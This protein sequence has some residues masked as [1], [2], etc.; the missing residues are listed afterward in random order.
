[1][2]LKTRTRPERSRFSTPST[3]PR[4]PVPPSKCP[5]SL[6]SNKDVWD[7]TGASQRGEEGVAQGSPIRLHRAPLQESRWDDEPQGRLSFNSTQSQVR[8]PSVP[9]QRIPL[10]NS[11]PLVARRGEGLEACDHG[12]AVAPRHPGPSQ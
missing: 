7:R 12:Q 1:M 2:G 4:T 6:Q 10:G 9:P 8:S 3:S 11:L 5:T